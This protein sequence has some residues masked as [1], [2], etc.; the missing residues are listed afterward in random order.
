MQSISI[1][2]NEASIFIHLDRN[3]VTAE[4]VAKTVNELTTYLQE[5]ASR[6]QSSV[7]VQDLSFLRRLPTVSLPDD[8]AERYKNS[9]FSREELYNDEERDKHLYGDAQ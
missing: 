4:T 7:R 6:E 9:T 8:I 1:A 5:I 3:A 2:A